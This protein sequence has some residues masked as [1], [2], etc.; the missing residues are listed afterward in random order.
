MIKIVLADDHAVVRA[1]IRQFLE[2]AADITVVAEAEDGA[3]AKEL[4]TTHQPDVAVLDIQM[5]QIT[6][7]E[8]TRWL[9]T[10]YPDIKILILTAFDDEPYIVAVLQAGAHGYVL[11]TSSPERLIEAVQQVHAGQSALDPEITTHLMAHIAQQ[12]ADAEFEPLT[13]REL[14]VLT[15]AGTGLTNKE[16][17]LKLG[18]SDRTV[19]GHL[20]KSFSKLRA[21]SRTKAVMRAVSLGLI[22]ADLVS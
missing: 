20:A 4:I 2:Q 21:N 10:T 5:P 11:K 7:I 8:L 18:I 22:D 15:L 9:Q 13:E 3:Q 16:I 17:G 19:Q 12:R 1:G 6:G 14:E